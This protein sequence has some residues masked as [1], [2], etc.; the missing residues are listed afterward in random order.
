[1]LSTIPF[2]LYFFSQALEANTGRY[3]VVDELC[4]YYPG[5]YK[6]Y[7]SKRNIFSVSEKY[8]WEN[9]TDTAHWEKNYPPH[10]ANT[11]ESI[12]KHNMA[13]YRECDAEKVLARLELTQLCVLYLS[14][15]I[16]FRVRRITIDDMLVLN[17]NPIELVF[18]L[19][20]LLQLCILLLISSL[21]METHTL[22]SFKSTLDNCVTFYYLT[23]G[24]W[25]VLVIYIVR[26]TNR[27]LNKIKNSDDPAILVNNTEDE[28]LTNQRRGSGFSSRKRRAS[29]IT[30]ANGAENNDDIIDNI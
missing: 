8:F 11:Q 23:G 10:P 1:M 28:N 29:A 14:S 2:V 27:K 7:G 25:G 16:I 24:I 17:I 22:S 9:C 6:I 19:Q 13:R 5:A 20:I 3:F 21:S 18:I 4:H 26:D 12:L 15:Q 30:I